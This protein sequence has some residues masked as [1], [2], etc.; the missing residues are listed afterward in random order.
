MEHEHKF[1]VKDHRKEMYCECGISKIYYDHISKR[2]PH[3][4]PK[5]GDM[6][7]PCVGVKCPLFHYDPGDEQS[8]NGNGDP[9]DFEVC[10]IPSMRLEALRRKREET[11]LKKEKR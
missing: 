10:P 11:R 8:C 4:I 7:C 1:I 5:P 3:K 9:A 2:Y 6:K